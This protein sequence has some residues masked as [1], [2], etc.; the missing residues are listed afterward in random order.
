MTS[1]PVRKQNCLDQFHGLYAITHDVAQLSPE[2][3][4]D[5]VVA[6]ID[7]GARIIQYRHKN[8]AA[9]QREQQARALLDCCRNHAIPLVINDDAELAA[10]IGADGVHLGQDDMTL[11]AARARLGEQAIIGTSCYNSIDLAI[12]AQKN[13][14]DYVAF[15][16][17]FASATKP[18]AI[19]ADPALLLQAKELL[20]VPVVAIG[21][22][23]PDN[24]RALVNAGADMLAAI[25]G[26]FAQTDIRVAAQQYA[27]LFK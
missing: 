3:L 20:T 10:S 18:Q 6:A 15:G 13:G 19:E 25:N 21:G 16:R 14:A 27:Q 12:A 5:Q 22:I 26:L 2:A 8:P 23:T 7:G 17:F 24:G 11:Q 9:T 1:S 4:C